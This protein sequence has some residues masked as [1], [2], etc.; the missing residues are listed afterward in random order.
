[1]TAPVRGWVFNPPEYFMHLFLCLCEAREI[2]EATRARID[3]HQHLRDKTR[4]LIAQDRRVTI[5]PEETK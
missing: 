5:T 2:A 4:R 1:M 3:P